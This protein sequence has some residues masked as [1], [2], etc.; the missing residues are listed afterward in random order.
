[1]VAR[2]VYTMLVTMVC[3]HTHAHTTPSDVPHVVHTVVTPECMAHTMMV[4]LTMMARAQVV[5]A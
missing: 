5:R 3:A 2:H 1:M 4:L